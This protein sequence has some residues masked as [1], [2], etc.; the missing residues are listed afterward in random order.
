[1]VASALLAS[2]VVIEGLVK[3]G[4]LSVSLGGAEIRPGIGSLARSVMVIKNMVPSWPAEITYF[5]SGDRMRRE[6]SPKC[7]LIFPIGTPNVEY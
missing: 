6:T 3:E 1:V 7:S 5:P 4:W 2:E